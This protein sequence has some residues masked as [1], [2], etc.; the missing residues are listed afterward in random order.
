MVLARFASRLGLLKIGECLETKMGPVNAPN[1]NSDQ[2][3]N[4]R[5]CFWLTII[6]PLIH[7]CLFLEYFG[8]QI[9]CW[10][11]HPQIA[12]SMSIPIPSDSS[13]ESLNYSHI[14]CILATGYMLK[15]KDSCEVAW[16]VCRAS[17]CFPISICLDNP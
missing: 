13:Q 7:E 5:C 14:W 11:S 2:R 8:Q 4:F 17:S 16:L 12:L 1:W 3:L 10:N 6:S 9:F 15:R